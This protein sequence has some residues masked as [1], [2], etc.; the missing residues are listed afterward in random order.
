MLKL[1]RVMKWKRL[2]FAR[3]PGDEARPRRRKYL[4]ALTTFII[5]TIKS[6]VNIHDHVRV[7]VM[8]SLST[9]LST[10]LDPSREHDDHGEVSFLLHHSIRKPFTLLQ[11]YCYMI[12]MLKQYSE[13]VIF[14]VFYHWSCCRGSTIPC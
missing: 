1:L 5:V 6:N 7:R 13:Q 2:L 11:Y 3:R 9:R 14:S 10:F 8:S 4:M 12:F